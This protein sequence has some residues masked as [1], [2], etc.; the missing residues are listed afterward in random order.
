MLS[1]RLLT[2]ILT[3][4]ACERSPS[5]AVDAASSRDAAPADPDAGT[6]DQGMSPDASSTADAGSDED[7][8]C[9]RGLPVDTARLRQESRDRLRS[10][11]GVPTGFEDGELWFRDGVTSTDN[12][13]AYDQAAIY[14]AAP[15][16]PSMVPS[17]LA[18]TTRWAAYAWHL[19]GYRYVI[20]T[21][22]GSTTALDLDWGEDRVPVNACA[23][24]RSDADP[25]AL[26]ALTASASARHPALPIQRFSELPGLLC[27][28]PVEGRASLDL[29]GTEHPLWADAQAFA[30]LIRASRL[31]EVIEWSPINYGLPWELDVPVKL[32]PGER[33]YPECLRTVSAS[34]VES[35]KT[36][37]SL[38]SLG[39]PFGPGWMDNP[40]ACR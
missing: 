33:L 24:F 30:R 19:N 11:F 10:F 38:P 6:P 9:A 18:G 13:P 25:A 22:H 2:L 28:G 27:W 5:T 40:D 29:D 4:A 32:S 12:C 1:R 7:A 23:V 26:E 31:L 14:Y 17:E 16:D 8:A 36:L 37:A 3:L 34:W 39:A 20:Y 21:T 35:R 15:I